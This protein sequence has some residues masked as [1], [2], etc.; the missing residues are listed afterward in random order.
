M[1]APAEQQAA[2]ETADGGD[3]LAAARAAREARRR[4]EQVFGGELLTEPCWDLLLDLFIA[5]R[6]GKRL[7]ITAAC[8]ALP[9]PRGT[10]QRCIAHLAD[11]GL[12][13]RE[14]G[15]G[16]HGVLYLAPTER[17]LAKLTSLLSRPGQDAEMS[18]A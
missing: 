16:D 9:V 3:L 8:L 13:S 5:A 17:A 2:Q 18:A 14:T 7:S 10:A 15:P 12:I 11:V 4:L 6:E 1:I